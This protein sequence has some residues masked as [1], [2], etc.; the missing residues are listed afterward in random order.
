MKYVTLAVLFG[1]AALISPTPSHAK[2]LHVRRILPKITHVSWY[3]LA[4]TNFTAAPGLDETAAEMTR[5]VR[6]ILAHS[7]PYPFK[8]S[9]DLHAETVGIDT[10]PQFSF[11]KT[12]G[13]GLLL[14][15]SVR[16]ASDGRLDVRFRLWDTISENQIAGR[17]YLAA[18]E[19]KDRLALTLAAEV[20]EILDDSYRSA[21]SRTDR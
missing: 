11:W 8:Q 20:F 1:V 19:F 2:D 12:R 16:E 3:S 21:P 7:G 14:V 13:V 9:D 10:P 6:D 15:A 18:R 4:V 17:T 5:S